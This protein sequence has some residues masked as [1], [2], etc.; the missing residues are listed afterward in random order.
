MFLSEKRA[1]Q[2]IQSLLD[3]GVPTRCPDWLV[4]L[5]EYLSSVRSEE[6]SVA[7]GAVDVS[8]HIS[9]LGQGALEFDDRIHNLVANIQTLSAA[10][11]EMSA[12]AS[13]VGGL[14]QDVLE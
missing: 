12:S 4:P 9:D 11:E 5:A 8:R 2:Q 6:L 7:N 10:I 14:G 1:K 13:E 3:N